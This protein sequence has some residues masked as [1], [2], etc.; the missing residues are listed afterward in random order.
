MNKT[1]LSTREWRAGAVSGDE[2][3]GEV[4][5]GSRLRSARYHRHS[6]DIQQVY[7]PRGASQCP[8]VFCLTPTHLESRQKTVWCKSHGQGL[9]Q[10]EYSLT[11]YSKCSFPLDFC[12]HSP[13]LETGPKGWTDASFFAAGGSKCGK[14]A[15]RPD[16]NTKGDTL[17]AETRPR[18]QSARS[19]RL[20]AQP[21]YRTCERS[22]SGGSGLAFRRRATYWRHRQVAYLP[23]TTATTPLEITEQERNYLHTEPA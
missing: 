6:A 9:T 21:S 13:G 22:S 1:V 12:R 5:R 4:G 20:H 11:G 19:P 3:Q 15:V 14:H 8:T 2:I 18:T 7:R 16:G 23:G 10:L 17:R